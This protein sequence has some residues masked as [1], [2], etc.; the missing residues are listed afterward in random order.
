MKS[1]PSFFDLSSLSY[2]PLDNGYRNI[3]SNKR[4]DIDEKILFKI[5]REYSLLGSVAPVRYPEE[6]GYVKDEVSRTEAR[7]DGKK[8]CNILRAQRLKLAKANGIILNSEECSA[9]GPCAGT[10]E[11]CEEELEYL[12]RMMNKIVKIKRVYPKFDP[13]REMKL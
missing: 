8:V 7:I 12:S 6:K 10:C 13:E 5:Q 1:Y 2:L 4:H 9:I 3:I 11:K